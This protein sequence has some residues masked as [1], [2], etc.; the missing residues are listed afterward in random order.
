MSDCSLSANEVH[1][2]GDQGEE[3][4]QVNEEAAHVQEEK[5]A[6]PEQDQYNSQNQKHE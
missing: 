3:E 2:D 4:E 1:D 6:E 5:S